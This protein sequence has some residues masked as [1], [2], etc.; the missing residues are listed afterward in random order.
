MGRSY[1][2]DLAASDLPPYSPELN[3]CD[4]MWDTVKDDTCNQVFASVAALRDPLQRYWEDAQSVLR[5]IGRDWFVVQLNA[6]RK[7][8]RSASFKQVI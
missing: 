2:E 6:S 8:R 4:Q 1:L 5:L 3:P 7:S